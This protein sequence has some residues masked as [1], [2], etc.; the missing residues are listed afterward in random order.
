[1][2]K[3]TL[4]LTLFIFS[5]LVCRGQDTIV[6]RIGNR[7]ACHILFVGDNINFKY[8]GDTAKHH[9]HI[10]TYSV[11]YVRYK[12]GT[13]EFY[14]PPEKI[15]DDISINQQNGPIELSINGGTSIPL[16]GYNGT[17]NV[18]NRI[19]DYAENGYSINI[20]ADFPV[21][22]DKLFFSVNTFLLDNPIG[23]SNLLVAANTEGS[24]ATVYSLELHNTGNFSYKAYTFLIGL[25]E[26]VRIHKLYFN[27]RA[28]GGIIL[29]HCPLIYGNVSTYIVANY[30]SNL[31]KNITEDFY[32]GN[33]TTP[34]FGYDAGLCIGF[35]FTTKISIQGNIDVT[36]TNQGQFLDI[37]PVFY[38]QGTPHLADI[39]TLNTTLGI[40]Y[41][42]GKRAK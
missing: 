37:S 16:L 12:D 5:F 23:L 39:T 42:L 10:S 13:K 28:S 8:W 3:F 27:A 35:Q 2:K 41:I 20:N 7:F 29:F 1:M 14:N 19:S 33:T 4:C 38:Y 11:N 34:M 26:K 31:S 18:S 30:T 40:C 9:F 21:Y 15:P 6:T 25:T 22:K 17:F 36:G 32:F 24:Y